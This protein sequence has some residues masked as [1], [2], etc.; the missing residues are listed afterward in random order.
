MKKLNLILVIIFALNS[1][2]SLADDV[3]WCIENGTKEI[4][5]LLMS[6]HS[7]ILT[8]QFELST[9]KLAMVA[10][11]SKNKTLED[12]VSSRAQEIGQSSLLGELEQ[13]YTSY[14]EQK[15]L[16]QLLETL[17][18]ANYW[19][20]SVRLTNEESALFSELHQMTA[21]NSPLNRT[22]SAILWLFDRVSKEQG[23]PGSADYNQSLSSTHIARI[24]GALDA[25]AS[26]DFSAVIKQIEHA[27]DELEV[28]LSDLFN[29]LSSE[30]KLHCDPFDLVS[31]MGPEMYQQAI[32]SLG[33]ENDWLLPIKRALLTNDDLTLELSGDK[34]P[35]EERNASNSRP[36]LNFSSLADLLIYDHYYLLYRDIDRYQRELNS[37]A[38]AQTIIEFH[39]DSNDERPYAIIDKKQGTLYLVSKD[40]EVIETQSVRVLEATDTFE[41][42]GAGVYEVEASTQRNLALRDESGRG[43]R[44]S[45]S[46]QSGQS[47]ALSGTRLYILPNDSAHLFKV[48]NG[49]LHFTTQ[50]RRTNYSP[51][52]YS[53]KS[54]RERKT[55]FYIN[56][57]ERRN[58]ISLR[59]VNQLSKEKSRLM[60]LY[61]LDNDEYNELARLAFGILGNESDYGRSFKYHVKE[62]IPLVVALLKGEGFNTAQN[63]RGLTQIKKVPALIEKEYGT[64]KEDLGVPE[65]AAV[66]TL[67]F[68]ADALMELKVKARLNP[69]INSENQY[70]YLHYIYT[71]RPS[72]ITERTAT[73]EQNIYLRQIKEAAAGLLIL[74]RKD[75]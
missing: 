17:E 20:S 40:G 74:E 14:G 64:K 22:D 24:L 30:W 34:N 2:Q 63:S 60:K 35:N 23:P 48:K 19:K 52:N 26:A 43:L 61:R 12:Y 9:L 59:F 3:R 11:G 47:G 69:D 4:R 42:G 32:V 6:D 37:L 56:D 71:G 73:P 21:A 54:E 68:L 49:E 75:S 53:P 50:E 15:S 67:G 5:S 51:Y 39:K 18:L 70:D 41:D 65:H 29:H 46:P 66:A 36:H 10:L 28:A 1:F 58:S 62:S 55:V 7:N 16:D 8:R 13:I 45:I 44:L 33:R 25:H 38:D 27:E 72:E 57:F 31:C